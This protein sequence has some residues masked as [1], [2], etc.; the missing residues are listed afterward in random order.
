MKLRAIRFFLY[1]SYTSKDIPVWS[2]FNF[3]TLESNNIDDCQ[4]LDVLLVCAGET[5]FRYNEPKVLNW[6][7]QLYHAGTIVGGISNASV[8]LAHAGLLDDR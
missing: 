5:S 4:I 6:L 1:I 2:S 8:L 7:R 3:P